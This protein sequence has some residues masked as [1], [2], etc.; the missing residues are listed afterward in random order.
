MPPNEHPPM[1]RRVRRRLLAQGIAL[2]VLVLLGCAVAGE[3]RS[4]WLQSELLS[5]FA[6]QLTF[7]VEP[8]PSESVRFPASGPYDHRLGYAQLPQFVQRLDGKGF[9]VER[10]ARWSERHLQFVERGGYPIFEEKTRAGLTLLDRQGAAVFAAR[11]PERTYESF[12]EIPPLVVETLLFIEHRELLDAGAPTRNPAI[13]W[14]R[15]AGVLPGYLQSL[16]DPSIKV[17]GASTLATQIEKYRHAPSGI[18]DSPRAKLQQMVTASV[19]AYRDGADTG[20]ARRQIVVDYL[21]STPLS[22][23]AAFGEVNGLGDGLWT[24]FGTD[25][26]HANRILRDDPADAE[27]C[28][29]RRKSTS[30][31]WR[32]CSPSGGHPTTCSRVADR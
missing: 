20:A 16:L 5:S 25:F 4:S 21:N 28:G 15:M 30:R 10:Q 23:R 9:E 8:G 27:G 29:T 11:F 12:E 3:V 31:C 2:T 19:R 22:A 17:A 18:T 6:R 32:C 1:T 7:R 26:A 24:W 14:H 13:E